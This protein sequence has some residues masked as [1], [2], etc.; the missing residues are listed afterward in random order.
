MKSRERV[1]SK[2]SAIKRHPVAFSSVVIVISYLFL[3]I[4]LVPAVAVVAILGIPLETPVAK[5]FIDAFP[6]ILAAVLVFGATYFLLDKKYNYQFNK[7]NFVK[8]LPTL[9]PS[10]LLLI[11]TFGVVF[12]V[13]AEGSS[14][15]IIP[16]TVIGAAIF[17]ALCVGFYEEVAFRGLFCQ[18]LLKTAKKN[19]IGKATIIT[20]LFF[21]LMHLEGGLM[22][23]VNAITFG[24]F[25]AAIYLRT[26][27]L[28][29]VIV[30]HVIWNAAVF[31]INVPLG[32]GTLLF[33]YARGIIDVNT[34]DIAA[35][36]SFAVSILT[37]LSPLIMTGIGL[38]LV[39]KRKHEE[40]KNLWGLEEKTEEQAAKSEAVPA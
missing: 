6:R 35:V 16:V 1:L 27:N 17:H 40:I 18:S 9:I 24:I 30:N 39:R 8:W 23:T 22:Q 26:K 21:G 3:Y 10:I 32:D 20:A 25:V 14:E 33:D 36:F 38:F 34:L 5:Q 12:T 11:V 13:K 29:L 15:L 28:W 31:I 2:K 7:E 19:P 37:L 4:G